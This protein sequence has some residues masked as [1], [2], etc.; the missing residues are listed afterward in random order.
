MLSNHSTIIANGYLIVTGDIIK[1]GSDIQGPFTSNDNPVKVFVGGTIS[2]VELTD[3]YPNFPVLN[4]TAPPT[5]PYPNSTCSYGNMTD[6]ISDPINTFFQYTCKTAN[7]KSN[8]SVCVANTI[9][10]TSASGTATAGAVQTA[11]QA[12][13]RTQI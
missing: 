2:P 8:S 5:T 9:N 7:V 10:L 4:C 6:M 11:S 3:N 1:N 12:T 13:Y